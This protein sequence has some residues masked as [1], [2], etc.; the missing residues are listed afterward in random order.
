MF[1]GGYYCF[2]YFVFVNM[3]VLVMYVGGGSEVFDEEIVNYCKCMSLVFC[4]C[5]Y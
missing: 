1:L 4:G 5:Y 2:D 3:G